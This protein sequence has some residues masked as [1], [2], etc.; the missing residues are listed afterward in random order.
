MC[1][2]DLGPEAVLAAYN[3]VLE[4]EAVKLQQDCIERFSCPAFTRITRAT[5]HYEARHVAFG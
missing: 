4:G 5:G 1:D 3:V 2:T